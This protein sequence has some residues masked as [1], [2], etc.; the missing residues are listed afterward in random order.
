M[1]DKFNDQDIGKV[2][3]ILQKESRKW[4]VPVVD[5]MAIST[6]DPFKVLIS[7]I[8]SLRTKD[9]TTAKASRKLFNKAGSP[10]KILK[11]DVKQIEELIYPV[12]FYRVKAKNIK[13]NC[14]ILVEKYNSVVPDDIDELLTFDGVGRKTANLVVTLGYGKP[15]ICVDIHVHRISNRLGYIKT[16]NPE[17]TEMEL[18]QKL[19]QKYWIKYN[20]IMVSFG[21]QICRPVSPFCSKCPVSDNCM[22]IG[23]SKNR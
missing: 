20:S 16:G 1:P 12:G 2:L 11:L 13:K 21:Q 15:G 9:E 10:E 7:T 18:R 19:P 6:R 22:K 3:K 5:F 17:K 23:V 14:K 4:N 8:L